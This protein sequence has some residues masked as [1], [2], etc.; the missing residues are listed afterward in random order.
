MAPRGGN[1]LGMSR[2]VRGGALI[3]Y[4][5]MLIRQQDSRFA[6]EAHPSGQPSAVFLSTAVKDS[7]IVFENPQHDFPQTIGYQRTDPGTLLAWV[8]GTQKGQHR[9]IEFP[10]RRAVCPSP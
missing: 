7:S 1:M 2:T 8:E 4:E 5:M 10:Y 3:E 9:R 6:Y